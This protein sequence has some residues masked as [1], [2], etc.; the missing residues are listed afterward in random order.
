MPAGCDSAN[1][2]DVY[3]GCTKSC[4][5][6]PFCGDKI[7][8]GPEQCDLGRDNGSTVGADGC[9]FGCTRHYCGDGTVDPGEI[10]D[11]GPLNGMPG[12]LCSSTCAFIIP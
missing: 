3:G 7:V 9:T 6:G 4:K 1:A 11:L 10:C 5:F 8:N 12:Q 2:D